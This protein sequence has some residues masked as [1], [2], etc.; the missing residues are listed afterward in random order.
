M[1]GV[2]LGEHHSEGNGHQKTKQVI[3]GL[4]LSC[5]LPQTLSKLFT[6]PSLGG[7]PFSRGL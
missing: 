7:E 6:S 3:K 4:E 5:L 1:T 2:T